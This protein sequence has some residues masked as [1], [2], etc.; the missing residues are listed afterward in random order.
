MALDK[1]KSV[2]WFASNCEPFNR[3]QELIQ[4]IQ[5][6][7]DVDVYGKCGNMICDGWDHC[8]DLLATN[9][10]FYASFEN[11]LCNDYISEKLYRPMEH[12][13][14]PIAFNGAKDMTQFAPPHS[15]IDANEFKTPEE[16]A[17]YLKYLID[18]PKEYIKYFWWTKYYRVNTYNNNVYA[19]CNL[20][21]RLNDENFMAKSHRY[22][23][24][25]NWF[26]DGKCNQTA[27]IQF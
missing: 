20:C 5:S 24:I 3:R 26:S 8:D 13:S 27:K 12:L 15:Y 21:V 14:V 23:S 22:K 10:K 2:A 18:R 11:S 19:L 9:Y 6:F 7:I 17:K 16:L 25:K 1:T 4:Q